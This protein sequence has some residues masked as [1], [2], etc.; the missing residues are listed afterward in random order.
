MF[1][2]ITHMA[3]SNLEFITRIYWLFQHLYS[4]PCLWRLRLTG[5]DSSRLA[6]SSP[7]FDMFKY[8]ILS[9]YLFQYY[10]SFLM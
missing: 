6:G 4:M 7:C 2:L 8:L 9:K 3:T 5:A 10:L 1:T